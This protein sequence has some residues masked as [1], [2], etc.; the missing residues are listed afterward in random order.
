M[1]T[2]KRLAVLFRERDAA[3]MRLARADGLLKRAGRSYCDARGYR[4]PLRL[5]SLRLEVSE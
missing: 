4:V 3:A 1:V 5:E 2:K